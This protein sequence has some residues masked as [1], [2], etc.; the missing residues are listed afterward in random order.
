MENIQS[1]IIAGLIGSA[2]GLGSVAQAEVKYNED[3]PV[4]YILASEKA[5]EIGPGA[6]HRI[7]LDGLQRG[8]DALLIVDVK[9]QDGWAWPYWV[10]VC[11]E[12]VMARRRAKKS[13]SILDQL[14]DSVGDD[15]ATCGFAQGRSASTTITLPLA[16]DAEESAS[17]VVVNDSP[18]ADAKIA[19]IQVSWRGPIRRT[20]LWVMSNMT[21]NFDTLLKS[22]F[23]DYAEFKI[24]VD[25]CGES[26]AFFSGRSNS[27]HFCTEFLSDM[28]ARGQFSEG[29]VA[30]VM[31]HEVGH[32]LMFQWALPGWDNESLVDEFAAVMLLYLEEDDLI[33]DF[34]GYWLSAAEDD[35]WIYRAKLSTHDNHAINIERAR[36]AAALATSPQDAVH[37]WQNI[38]YPRM[39]LKALANDL[40]PNPGKYHSGHKAREQLVRNCLVQGRTNCEAM[41]PQVGKFTGVGIDLY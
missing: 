24:I 6:M 26:N 21:D 3:A 32:G 14:S 22:L 30:G 36:D 11:P 25:E 10:G 33:G 28:A 23:A 27:I 13:A 4:A 34:A 20:P 31:L 7:D 5:V 41:I 37:R 15:G 16:P 1:T 18:T 9:V 2:L 38:I 40:R 8:E 19:D 12:S 29:A 17:V 39:T 35:D